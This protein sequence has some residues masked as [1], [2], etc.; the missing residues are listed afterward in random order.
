MKKF[1][2]FITV[3]LFLGVTD[4]IAQT[5]KTKY[6]A[7]P[8]EKADKVIGKKNMVVLDVRTPEEIAGGYIPGAI[9]Y[10]FNDPDFK[11]KISSLDKNKPYLV[12]CRSGK[13]SGKTIDMMKEMGFKRLYELKAGFPAYDAYKKNSKE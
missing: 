7:V 1:L 9:N 8:V 3:L 4:S 2:Y 6:K 13:R 10:N 5:H 12:Y 11:T